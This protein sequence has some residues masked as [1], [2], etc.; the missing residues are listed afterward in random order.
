MGHKALGI[1]GVYFK[2]TPNDLLEGND[3]MLGYANVM[4]SLTISDE[5]ELRQEVK[6]LTTEQNEITIMKI[7]HDREMTEMRGQLEKIVSLIQQNPKL[8]YV[9]PEA[10]AKGA[11]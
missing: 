1:T 2:P 5:H 6:Q 11:H 9:K 3:K 10:L 8:A 7:K 4:K